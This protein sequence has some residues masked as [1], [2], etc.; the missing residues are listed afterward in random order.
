MT[1]SASQAKKFFEDIILNRKVWTIK[2]D[3]GIPALDGDGGVRSM[4]FW[5]SLRRVEKIIKNVEAYKGFEPIE[6]E[7]DVFKARWLVG[8]K[9]DGLNVGINWSGDRATGYDMVPD[10][11]LKNIEYYE[12]KNR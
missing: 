12:A 9:R 3:A 4:P 7:L 10:S 11:V 8:L 6:L 2:D 5:S 1:A